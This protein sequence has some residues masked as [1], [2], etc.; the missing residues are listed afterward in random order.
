M[1]RYGKELTVIL[2]F[3]LLHALVTLVSR[4][5]GL[6]DHLM[7]TTL[8]ML[9]AVVLCNIRKVNV[10]ATIVL[11]VLV[12]AGGFYIAKCL[13]EF[14]HLFIDNTYIRGSLTTFFS[15]LVLGVAVHYMSLWVKAKGI[16]QNV[17][18]ISSY[19]LMLVFT[20]IIIARLMLIIINGN[21][22]YKGNM[23]LNVI[24]DYIFCCFSLLFLAVNAVKEFSMLQ[25]AKQR[26]NIAQYSYIRLQ[27]QIKPHFMFNNLNILNSLICENQN[28]AASDFVYKLAYLYRYM[29]E[30]EDEKLVTLQEEMEFVNRY[31]DLMKVRFESSF[32]LETDLDED[33]LS[34]LVVPCSIQLLVENAIKHNGGTVQSPLR[35]HISNDS[36]HIIVWNNRLKKNS[37]EPSTSL[38]LKYIKELYGDVSKKPLLVESRDE[39]YVVKLPVIN[40]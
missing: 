30:N 35:I 39:E 25:E 24:I 29:I 12:N 4:W 11:L 3:S 19:W 22:L 2:S 31:S 15:S 38:G 37:C 9:M 18:E 20:V 36:D 32:N 5:Q 34:S 1:R 27:Q 23:V 21:A 10:Y 16:G 13:G 40:I 6:S 33:I 7:L 8:T 28:K 17:K 14:L 26:S